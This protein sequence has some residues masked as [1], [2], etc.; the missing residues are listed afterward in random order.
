MRRAA[1]VLTLAAGLLAPAAAGALENARFEHPEKLEIGVSTD[2]IAISSDFRGV[3]LTIFGAIEGYDPDLL[4]QGKYGVVVALEGPKDDAT[5][6]KKERFF[7]IWVNRHS[8]TFELVPE[9]Y[10][11]SSTRDVETIAP[12]GELNSL[13]IGIQHIRLSPTGYFGDGS[14]LT[15]FRDAFRRLKEAGG[16]YQRDPGG[17]QFISAS[18]FKATVRLPASVPNGTHMVRAHLFRDGVFISEKALPLRVMKTGIEQMISNAAYENAT[19]YGIFAVILA[20]VTGWIAS[21][22]FRKD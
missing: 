16:F 4:A 13:G 11:L 22:V 20:V 15:E 2:E 19:A 7:G 8:M 14:N 1:A 10:S 9:S 12:D 18:L 17:V 3:D 21:I 6:R 5:V